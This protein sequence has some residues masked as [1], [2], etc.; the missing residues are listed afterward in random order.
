MNKQEE[1]R[2]IR[3]RSV[4][5]VLEKHVERIGGPKALLDSIGFLRRGLDRIVA[6]DNRYQMV[7]SGAADARN[8]QKAELADMTSKIC[9]LISAFG[10]ATGDAELMAG[11]DVSESE[12]LGRSDE[13][14][15]QFAEA[16]A[17][18]IDELGERLVD[19]GVDLGMV[20]R[21]R[22]LIDSYR[23]TSDGGADGVAEQVSS[24]SELIEAFEGV[25]KLLDARI[26]KL[27]E[28]C[29]YEHP[30]FYREYFAARVYKDV[31]FRIRCSRD[32][33]AALE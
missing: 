14:M 29:E 5:S 26:D 16:V 4:L 33:A 23:S 21:F 17:G 9:G 20:E 2:Y 10:Y 15:M 18:M 22:G 1:N 30:C 13:E 7:T 6:L 19:Y 11:M 8:R 12:L 25:H 32:L 28:A 3:D 31:G 24:Q 27:V